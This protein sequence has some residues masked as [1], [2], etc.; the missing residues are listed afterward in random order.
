[1]SLPL[2]RRNSAKLSDCHKV[3]L[4]AI[5]ILI[6]A[7]GAVWAYLHHFARRLGELG[8]LPHPAES[9]SLKLHGAAAMAILVIL[10]TLL[11]TH[12]RFAWHSKR[13][14]SNGMILIS[15][16]SFLILTGYGLY[17]FGDERLRSWTSWLHL[18]V[19]LALPLALVLHIRSGRRSEVTPIRRQ[20]QTA[21]LAEKSPEL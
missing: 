4:Y 14:R 16:F 17:Y 6:Y 2:M 8:E 1:V 20:S 11:P 9:W 19:G 18:V 3:W 12:V 15:V 5:T 10:G 7:S 21:N 13:N